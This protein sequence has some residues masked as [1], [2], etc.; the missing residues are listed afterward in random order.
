MDIKFGSIFEEFGRILCACFENR[1]EYRFW[2]ISFDFRENIDVVI[3]LL[4]K[5]YLKRNWV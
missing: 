1:G 3:L 4:R 2:N 5:L